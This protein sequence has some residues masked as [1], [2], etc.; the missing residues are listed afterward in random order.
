MH[1]EKIISHI[2]H[3]ELLKAEA[4]ILLKLEQPSKLACTSFVFNAAIVHMAARLILETNKTLLQSVYK[5]L[6]ASCSLKGLF[7][8]EHLTRNFFEAVVEG[9]HRKI[10]TIRVT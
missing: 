7:A 10:E 2:S 4:M 1:P 5:R 9:L 6:P 8:P 3:H